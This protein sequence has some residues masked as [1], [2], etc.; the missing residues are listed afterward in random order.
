MKHTYYSAINVYRITYH[1]R[2]AHVLGTLALQRFTFFD[3]WGHATGTFRP[4]IVG[5]EAL[6]KNGEKRSVQFVIKIRNEP[7]YGGL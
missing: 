6:R 5:Y 2:D 1:G 3:R 4:K 7:R